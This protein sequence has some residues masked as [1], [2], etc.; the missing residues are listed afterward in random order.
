VKVLLDEWENVAGI[1]IAMP[2]LSRALKKA[3]GR[4]LPFGS[5]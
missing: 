3:P 2:S 4:L 5:N 1:V